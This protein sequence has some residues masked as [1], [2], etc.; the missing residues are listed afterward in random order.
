MC[1]LF[2]R[3]L[4]KIPPV[5]FFALQGKKAIFALPHFSISYLFEKW[6]AYPYTGGHLELI[7]VPKS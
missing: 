2:N 7:E 5:E 4:G 6:P 1:A 3:A